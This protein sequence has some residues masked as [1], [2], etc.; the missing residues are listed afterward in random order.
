[1]RQLEEEVEAAQSGRVEE[2]RVWRERV[3]RLEESSQVL[4]LL[5]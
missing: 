3:R 1:M 4:R 5:A 2:G